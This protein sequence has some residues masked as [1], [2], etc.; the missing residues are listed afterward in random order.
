MRESKP[1]HLGQA[2]GDVSKFGYVLRT[3]KH[4]I[5]LPQ[6]HRNRAGRL[7]AES[8]VRLAAPQQNVGVNKD[9]H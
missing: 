5:V 1:V 9:T 3:E 7:G 2:R 8:V 6:Q 4:R